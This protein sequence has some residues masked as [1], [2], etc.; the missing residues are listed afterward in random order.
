MDKSARSEMSEILLKSSHKIMH[1]MRDSL[2]D[3]KYATFGARFHYL[4]HGKLPK[5]AIYKGRY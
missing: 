1:K 3:Y 5:S 4:I 2:D